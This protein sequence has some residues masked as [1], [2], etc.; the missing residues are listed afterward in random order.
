MEIN[1]RAN[2]QDTDKG[3]LEEIVRTLLDNDEG[4]LDDIASVTYEGNC[5]YVEI[6][7]RKGTKLEGT[8]SYR[9]IEQKRLR[10][11]TKEE[12]IEFNKLLKHGFTS[13]HEYSPR[14]LAQLRR[15]DNYLVRLLG[16]LKANGYS[17]ARARVYHMASPFDLKVPVVVTK[18]HNTNGKTNLSQN[19]YVA[20]NYG[21]YMKMK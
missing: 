9:R 10:T 3:L 13:F 20:D 4:K 6:T 17:V 19:Y 11:M 8:V 15:K 2:K 21:S 7:R 1:D 16:V 5:A 14:E 18:L 12:K